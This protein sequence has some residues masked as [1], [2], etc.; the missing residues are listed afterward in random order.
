[1][2]S[3]RWL[4]KRKPNWSRLEDLLARSKGRGVS[5]LDHKDLQE[6]GL[7]Y[8][9]TAS[10]LA[11]AREDI[12]S[13]QLAAY[14]NSL[15]GRTHNLIYMGNKPKVAGIVRFYSETYPRIFRE[16]WPQTLLAFAIFAVTGL[17]AF[18]L[19]MRDPTFAHRLLGTHMMET[20]E[21]REMW[22]HSIVTIKPLAASSIMTNNLSVAFATFASGITAGVGTVWMMVLNG[23]LIGVIGAATLQAGMAGQL[24]TFVVPHGVLEL[25]AI[26]IAG[27]AGFEIARGMLFPGLLPRRESLA[28]A[29]GRAAQLL[30]GTIPMLIVAGIIEG[31]LSPS[32]TAA[33]LKFLFGAVMFAALV[34]YLMRAQQV[35]KPEES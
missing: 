33:P 35:R 21:K 14:L 19:T 29:G 27:G 25:P 8:R 3:T 13:S 24:W 22:T 15:L 30:L 1:M 20:I 31:F 28:R 4:E 9:Q 12:T 26:F 16:L 5:A 2:I 7:L 23:L 6:L 10:D 11:I 32:E 34:T 18:I 17:A